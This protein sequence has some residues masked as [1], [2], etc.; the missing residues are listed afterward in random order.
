M[1]IKLAELANRTRR[2]LNEMAV[3]QER[4]SRLQDE[5]RK[6]LA[7]SHSVSDSIFPAC[8][9]HPRAWLPMAAETAE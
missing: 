5:F 2:I 7:Q 3:L 9:R 1:E 4:S 8:R 6:A